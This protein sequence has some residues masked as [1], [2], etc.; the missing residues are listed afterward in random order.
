MKD[1][2]MHLAI[3]VVLATAVLLLAS[4]DSDRLS[5]DYPVWNLSVQE[6]ASPPRYVATFD[7]NPGGGDID[8]QSRCA[9]IQ[10]QLQAG[11]DD[12][13]Y[14]CELGRFRDR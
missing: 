11:R 10:A 9:D 8:N 5:T 7:M 1:A 4:C 13:R 2:E 12:V 6:G 3:K 14:H